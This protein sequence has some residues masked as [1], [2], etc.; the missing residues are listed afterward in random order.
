MKQ[1]EKER[2]IVRL[3]WTSFLNDLGSEVLAR[4]VPLY[5]TGI[6]GASMSAVGTI[7]GIAESTATLLKPFFG[8]LSDRWGARKPFILMGYALSAVSRPILAIAGSW[9]IVAM[10]RFLDRLGKGVR[11][12]PRDA[13]IADSGNPRS[14]GRNFGINRALDTLGGVLGLAAFGLWVWHSG[15]SALTRGLWTGFTLAAAIPGLLS[16]LL[17]A[18]AVTEVQRASAMRKGLQSSQ[19]TEPRLSAAFQRY[20]AV[21]TLFSLANASDAFIVMRA[22]ELGFSL[23]E[24]LAMIAIS[25]TVSASTALPAAALSDRFG[26]PPL[27]A[28]GWGVFAASYAAMGSALA[29]SHKLVFFAIVIAYGLFYGFTEGVERALVADLA[30]EAARGK[31][32]GAFGFAVGAAALPASIV[33]GAIWDRWGSQAAFTTS[34]ALALLACGLLLFFIRRDDPGS[35]DERH[36]SR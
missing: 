19:P 10:L 32:Y 12:A 3:G 8:R 14:H 28:A 5:V 33:F 17:V 16:V 34:A 2:N 7:E 26:R 36:T 13:L 29:G 27:I 4:L 11:T 6:L 20:L 31:A 30:P 25:F 22:K 23:V 24:I 9:M 35:A 15:E 1:Q 21:V 18:V